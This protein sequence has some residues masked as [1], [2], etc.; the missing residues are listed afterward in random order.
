V[1]WTKLLE[2]RA[3]GEFKAAR[4]LI[5]LVDED[6]LGWKPESGSN[7]MTTGQLLAHLGEAC[8]AIAE[9]FASGDWARFAPPED[10]A[11]P[12]DPPP[13]AETVAAAREAL[14]ADEAL[15]LAMIA[16]VGEDVLATQEVGAPWNPAPR[17]MGEQF[18]DCI[19]H[20]TSHKSQLFY[21][22]KLQG[23]AVHTGHLWGLEM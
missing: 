4:G 2:N 20:L 17:L 3:G 16:K 18:L 23:K 7:W 14:D 12:A 10:G 13:T 1:T 22:L 19:E 5:A 8:G 15:T 9:C 11:A 6:G 21:Y